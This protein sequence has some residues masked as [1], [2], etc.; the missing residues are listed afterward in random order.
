MKEHFIKVHEL[1]LC[2]CSWGRPEDPLLLL[3]HGFLDQGAAWSLVA[4]KLSEDG[5]RVVAPDAR[6]HGRS[7]HIG[8]GGTYHF[9]D[10]LVDLEGILTHLGEAPVGLIGHS[11]GGTV[12]SLYAGVRPDC[13]QNLVVVEGLGPV[14]DNHDTAVQRLETHLNQ[15]QKP[16]HHPVYEDSQAAASRL[17]RFTPGIDPDLALSLAIR[18]TVSVE[19]G[20]QWSWDPRHRARFAMPFLLD[21]FM[22]AIARIQLPTTLVYGDSSWYQSEDLP[23][24][25]AALSYLVARK[26]LPGGHALHHDAPQ[27]LARIIADACRTG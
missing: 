25:E 7:G 8:I 11:M 27:E 12:A 20:V 5:F 26:T 3:L 13:A 15:L 14:G 9:T 19:G 10:Y 6:G 24:R 18:S 16:P 4:E 2:L 17:T 1:P 23:A 22:D 21:R